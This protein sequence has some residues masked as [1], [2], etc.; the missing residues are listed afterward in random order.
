MK[1]IG[2]DAQGLFGDLIVKTELVGRFGDEIENHYELVS[3]IEYTLVGVLS[4]LQ[5]K[6]IVSTEWCNSGGGGPFKSLICNDR[7]DLGIV[8]E[9]LWDERGEEAPH[10]F[11]NDLLAGFR[12]ALNDDRS[13]DALLGIIQ[14]FD[15]GATT[16]SLEASTRVFDAHRLTLEARYFGNTTDDSSLAG[17]RNESFVK[18]AFS[19]FF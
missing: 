18:L 5:I 4:P 10:P 8:V 7:M 16:V 15:G 9:Y 1:Q 6:D 13:T 14:D 3:G 19:Y 17:F 11:Q 12:F 2:V